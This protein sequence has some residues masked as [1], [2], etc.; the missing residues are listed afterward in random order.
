MRELT[1]KQLETLRRNGRVSNQ[2]TREAICGA[3]FLLLH[4][5]HF[6]E[7]RISEIIQRAGVSRSAF[8]RNFKKKEEILFDFVDDCVWQVLRDLGEDIEENWRMIFTNVRAEQDKFIILADAGLG[9]RFLMLLN[10][11][12]DFDDP[13]AFQDTL[14]RGMIY[15][16]IQSYV[17]TGFPD[18][19]ETA[20]HVM[21]GMRTIARDAASGRL[22]VDYLDARPTEKEPAAR[23]ARDRFSE[24]GR[25]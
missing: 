10:Q 12:S 22:D 3:L 14:W 17:R 4:E 21:T 24:S 11:L 15:N 13:A 7:I 25:T 6:D 16:C 18:P 19:A 8:Y 9:D 2:L 5:K 1:Q 23:H 20:K